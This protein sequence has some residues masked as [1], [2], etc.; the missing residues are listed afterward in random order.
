MSVHKEDHKNEFVIADQ[1]SLVGRVYFLEIGSGEEILLKAD[2]GLMGSEYKLYGDT[3][4]AESI[5]RA[6][7]RNRIGDD[8]ANNA[9]FRFIRGNRR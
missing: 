1:G 9:V 3:E 5:A 2:P 8:A 6:E 7:I 4:T